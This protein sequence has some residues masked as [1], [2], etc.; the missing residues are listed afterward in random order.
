MFFNP[1]TWNQPNPQGLIL[2]PREVIV[3]GPLDN[4]DQIDNLDCV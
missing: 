3:H 4:P 2:I 1:I